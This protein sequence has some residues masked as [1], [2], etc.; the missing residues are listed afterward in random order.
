MF[1]PITR[2]SEGTDAPPRR[3]LYLLA[4]IA[5]HLA[6]GTLLVFLSMAIAERTDDLVP[7][8]VQLVSPAP[9]RQGEGDMAGGLRVEKAVTFAEKPRESRSP[10]PETVPRPPPRVT[11]SAP[12]DPVDR[13]DSEPS[14]PA[15]PSPSSPE[16]A[17]VDGAGSNVEGSPEGPGG[18]RA[19]DDL[20]DGSPGGAGGGNAEG[21]EA[22]AHAGPGFRKPR[23]A[24][25]HCVRDGIRIPHGLQGFLSELIWVKVAIGRDGTPSLFQVLDRLPDER[26]GQ[27]IWEAIQKCR[28]IPG[29]DA[30]GR[31]TKI[32]VMIPIRFTG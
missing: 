3:W 21:E 28:W 20:A 22:P 15:P 11:S 29:T 14:A 1:E 18:G 5:V 12:R 10:G 31:P 7:I 27:A 19:S 32:W 9:V 4:S 30:R 17:E 8:S 2:S 23:Q 6:V 24:E 26:I 13:R 25:R 16:P